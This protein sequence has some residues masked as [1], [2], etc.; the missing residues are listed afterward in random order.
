MGEKFKYLVSIRYTSPGQRNHL[1]MKGPISLTSGLKKLSF[2]RAPGWLRSW[3]QVPGIKPHSRLPVQRVASFS[4]SLCPSAP[5]C[6]RLL[7]LYQKQNKQKNT[8][9][10][11]FLL[12]HR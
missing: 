6:K 5:A 8:P 3:S 1:I 9:K 12:F 2:L 4:L 7:F 11:S 10:L